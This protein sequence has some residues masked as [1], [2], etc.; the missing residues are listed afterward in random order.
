LPRLW[1]R[2]K[3]AASDEERLTG[4]FKTERGA[5]TSDVDEPTIGSEGSGLQ[6]SEGPVMPVVPPEPASQEGAKGTDRRWRRKKAGP[7][8]NPKDTGAEEAAAAAKPA[9][10]RRERG[11]WQIAVARVLA[12]LVCAAG[13]A[14]I[15][16]GYNGAASST[17]VDQQIPY[18]I[19]GGLLGLALVV[20]GVGLLVLAEVRAGRRR[21]PWPEHAD[22]V[23]SDSAGEPI[24]QATDVSPGG[25]PDQTAEP[26][27]GP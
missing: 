22:Q 10:R 21:H 6:T 17:F 4:T 25:G 7:E 3:G 11:R 15:A 9:P 16:L 8:E 26:P 23:R 2:T 13:F 14:A 20:L 18:L 1:R 27:A 19:S 24:A 12:L 5:P